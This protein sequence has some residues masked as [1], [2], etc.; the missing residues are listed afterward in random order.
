[1]IRDI[2]KQELK[3]NEKK[4]LALSIARVIV[5]DKKV[6]KDEIKY[7]KDAVT[8]LETKEELEQ[9]LDFV[10]KLTVPEL[11]PLNI[12]L[13]L[14]TMMLIYVIRAMVRNTKIL[15][16]EFRE[17]ISM[18]KKLSIPAPMIKAILKWA[19][20][21]SE[22][23]QQEYAFYEWAEHPDKKPQTEER[24]GV[25]NDLLAFEG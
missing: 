7:L 19:L 16:V 11:K 21:L 9:V 8:F 24:L 5:A 20:E 12:N 25:F 2:L 18:G 6:L 17:L 14:G 13:K 22:L 4:W 15:E 23:N 1:M 10:K 3:P